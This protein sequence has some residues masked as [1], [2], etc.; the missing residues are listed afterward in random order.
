MK[1]SDEN[2]MSETI[3][4]ESYELKAAECEHIAAKMPM[5]RSVE[6]IWIRRQS[7]AKGRSRLLR[8][9]GARGRPRADR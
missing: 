4:I 9:N 3:G 7:G 1:C 8:V 6:L 5:S 2:R